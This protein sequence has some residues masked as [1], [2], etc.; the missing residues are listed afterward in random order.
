LGLS[1]DI[2][3]GR[4]D[5]PCYLVKLMEEELYVVPRKS[6]KSV[7]EVAREY[8]KRLTDRDPTP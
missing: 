4:T 5:G 2:C 7:E 1:D 8:L 6:Y 3:H